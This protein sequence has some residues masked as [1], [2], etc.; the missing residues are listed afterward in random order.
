MIE[1]L[2]VFY[3]FLL[4]SITW[5]LDTLRHFWTPGY[6]LGESTVCT[7]FSHVVDIVHSWTTTKAIYEFREPLIRFFYVAS[8][9]V[10]KKTQ[11]KTNGKVGPQGIPLKCQIYLCGMQF[12]WQ[13]TEWGTGR[14]SELAPTEME[15]GSCG[16]LWFLLHMAEIHRRVATSLPFCACGILG[17]SLGDKILPTGHFYIQMFRRV[18]CIIYIDFHY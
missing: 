11:L 15:H 9:C 5:S 17:E 2:E 12:P 4:I 16:R 3:D 14:A 6:L 1:L 7:Q 10:R 13:L 18:I 8:L